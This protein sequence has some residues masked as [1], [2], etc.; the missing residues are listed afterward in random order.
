MQM[1][2]KNTM[3]TVDV[4]GHMGLLIFKGGDSYG[5]Y[6]SSPGVRQEEML[7]LPAKAGGFNPPKP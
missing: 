2:Q 4:L 3:A 6:L 5:Y 1:D 7:K